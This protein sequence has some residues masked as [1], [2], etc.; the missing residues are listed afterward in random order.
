MGQNISENKSIYGGISSL[1]LDQ[2]MIRFSELVR[3]DSLK[4]SKP[5]SRTN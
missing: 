5:F 4:F 3:Q 2:V 1:A